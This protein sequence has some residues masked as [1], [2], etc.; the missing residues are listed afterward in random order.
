MLKAR[1]SL[2]EDVTSGSWLPLERFSVDRDRSDPRAD[3]MARVKRWALDCFA[4]V[5][6]GAD[7]DLE[8]LDP[9]TFSP[10]FRFRVLY[11]L[12]IEVSKDIRPVFSASSCP[13]RSGPICVST[14]YEVWRCGRHE[15][16]RRCS[17]ASRF[18]SYSTSASCSIS[19]LNS[20]PKMKYAALLVVRR[21]GGVLPRMYIALWRRLER[22][23]T[24][25][26]MF[27]PET[28]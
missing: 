27:K 2:R 10:D 1:L 28:E 22:V 16:F 14:G 3:C 12:S 4:G 24:P 5:K 9:W 26:L 7:F 13:V 19:G 8:K 23:W 15:A 18:Q 25:G 6:L 20:S 21:S 17:S 11:G